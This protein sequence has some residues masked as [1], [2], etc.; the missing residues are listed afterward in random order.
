MKLEGSCHCGRVRFSCESDHPYPYQR[1]YCSICR[2]TGGAG[3]FMINLAGHASTLEVVG[4][5]HVRVYRALL[6]RDG[7]TVESDHERNFCGACGSHLWAWNRRW[8]EH[9]HPVASAVDTP[10]PVPPTHVHMM[11]ASKPAWV[12]VEGRP[13][14]ERFD[15]YPAQSIADWH[16]SH[17]A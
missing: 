12:E 11:V 4:T 3:G 13:D 16:A 10:L 6:E 5:E 8:P 2:K 7:A 9:L 1:C 14:D 15:R 17:L